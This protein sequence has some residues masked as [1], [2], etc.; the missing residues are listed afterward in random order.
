MGSNTDPRFPLTTPEKL[1]M[2]HSSCC[3]VDEFVFLVVIGKAVTDSRV[4]QQR[5]GKTT[6]ALLATSDL[7]TGLD[8][9]VMTGLLSRIDGKQGFYSGLSLAH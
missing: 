5:V 2:E 4:N 9:D 3:W 7:T 8:R 6:H 1:G